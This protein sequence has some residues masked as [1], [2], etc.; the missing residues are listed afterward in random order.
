MD[1][2]LRAAGEPVAKL[3]TDLRAGVEPE[4]IGEEI[5]EVTLAER[6]ARNDG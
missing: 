4:E 1:A 6:A 2:D 5:A 3:E